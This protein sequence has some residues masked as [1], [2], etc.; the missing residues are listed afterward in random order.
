MLKQSK[1]REHKIAI[2]HAFLGKKNPLHEPW[3]IKKKMTR[4]KK[5]TSVHWRQ[6]V[7]TQLVQL[8][9]T[10]CKDALMVARK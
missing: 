10:D 6:L 7:Q 4:Q 3:T 2:V 1:M 9:C 5:I 8:A